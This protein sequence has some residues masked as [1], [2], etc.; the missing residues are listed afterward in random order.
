[1]A[2]RLRRAWLRLLGATLNKATLRAAH[3]GRGPFSLIRH[4][5][6]KT[7]TVY[8]T[9]LMLAETKGGLVGELTYGPDV[10]WYRNIVAAG[11]AEILHNGTWHRIDRI[12]DFPTDAGYRAFGAPRNVILKLLRRREFVYLHEIDTS[13]SE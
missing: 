3:S 12:E 1:M 10:A 6:R 13:E 11:R 4:V 7:G 2:N 5:G 8:E 9:P